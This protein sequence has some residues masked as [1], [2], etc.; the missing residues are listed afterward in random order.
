MQ[1]EED[2]L[3]RR[4]RDAY[5]RERQERRQ[6]EEGNLRPSQEKSRKEKKHPDCIIM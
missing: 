2:H 1:A 6:R 4:D 3:A 5:V